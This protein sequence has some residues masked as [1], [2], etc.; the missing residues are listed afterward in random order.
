MTGGAAMNWRA[1]IYLLSGFL[2]AAPVQ[3]ERVFKRVDESGNVTY[4]SRPSYDGSSIE[5]RDISG[6]EDPDED[7]IA[8][9][10][11]IQYSPVTM[12]A[13]KK[14]KP[15]DQAREQLNKR[16]IPF[17]EKDPTSDKALYKEFQDLGGANV[18]PVIKVGD[19]VVNE[20]TSQALEDALNSAGY[21]VPEKAESSQEGGDTE[22]APPDEIR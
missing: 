13:I 4:E 21:P 2:V 20:Y 15:C 14:C 9:D 10:R 22:Q 19:A 7:A 8:L 5:E 6:G 17:T 18:V 11:A 1:L 12:Y 16:K 3:A